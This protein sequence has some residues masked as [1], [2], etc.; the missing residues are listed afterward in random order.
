MVGEGMRI[1]AG[2]KYLKQMSAKDMPT[3]PSVI[4]A[5]PHY[6]TPSPPPPEVEQSM[7]KHRG[8]DI[9]KV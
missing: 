2:G 8:E 6:I 4:V 1:V 3:R 5:N 7:T 9:V